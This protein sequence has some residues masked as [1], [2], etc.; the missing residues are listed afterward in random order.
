MMTTA[1]PDPLP[2]C[3]HEILGTIEGPEFPRERVCDI[4]LEVCCQ[5]W[6]GKPQVECKYYEKEDD[7]ND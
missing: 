4:D 6:F 5:Y 1:K 7:I 2:Y 3:I